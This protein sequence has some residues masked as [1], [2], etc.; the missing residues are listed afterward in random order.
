MDTDQ[1]VAASNAPVTAAKPRLPLWPAIVLVGVLASVP[2]MLA[3]RGNTRPCWELSTCMGQGITSGLAFLSIG[4][5]LLIGR[6]SVMPW[7]MPRMMA[8]MISI[9]S[10][11]SL[12]GA[13][14]ARPQRLVRLAPLRLCVS[15]L[16]AVN[17]TVLRRYGWR[18]AGRAPRGL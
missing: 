15:V 2:L 10:F 12:C 17:A 4:P 3:D 14:I 5:L 6:N 7:T 18:P 11:Y 13:K 1:A 9:K 16:I 8:W